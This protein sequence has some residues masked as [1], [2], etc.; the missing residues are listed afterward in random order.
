MEETQE[1]YSRPFLINPEMIRQFIT[2]HPAK[3]KISS[4]FKII[5]T[6]I[7]K[8]FF[9]DNQ[10]HHCHKKHTTIEICHHKIKDE[11]K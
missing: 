10:I 7:M 3:Q 4:G 1:Y 5:P 11:I 8:W 9:P 2:T 6:K